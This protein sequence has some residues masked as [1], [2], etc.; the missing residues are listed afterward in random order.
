MPSKKN[1]KLVVAIGL[2]LLGLI[3]TVAVSQAD[4]KEVHCY[5]VL[6]PIES[7]TGFS[8]IIES[9]CFDSFPESIEAATSGQV[10]LPEDIDP[11]TL[12]DSDLNP[13]LDFNRIV[14]NTTTVIGIDY[15]Y[16]NFG[17]SSYTWTVTGVG[18]TDS[19]SY[20][21]SQMPSGWDNSVSSARS[22]ANC[23]HYYHWENKDNKGAVLDCG[24][25]CSSMGVM[26]NQ[27]SSE[28]WHK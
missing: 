19:L 17:G 5:S 24:T 27:T 2:M 1:V 26:D 21:I 3:M 9:G 4:T 10:I 7:S 13:H 15:K 6:S 28:Q 25:S 12:T 22:Y 8:K 18:C 20:G 11:A 23:N 14:P 16:S